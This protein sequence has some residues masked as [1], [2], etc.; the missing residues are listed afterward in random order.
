MS[1]LNSALG[2]INFFDEDVSFTPSTPDTIK[3]WIYNVIQERGF[4]LVNL[5]YIFCSD[6]YLLSIN[7]EYLNHDAYTDII[8]FDHSEQVQELESDIYIS[9]GRV[10]EN[11]S[12]FNKKFDD[13]LHRVMIH[14][15]L[16]LMGQ[17]DKTKEEQLEMRKKEEA[18][19]SLRVE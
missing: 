3:S 19:L 11:A 16:H 5:N 2:E 4:L 9:I 12:Q 15:V 17:G 6:D 10:K 8:T 14:G 7:I 13:E 1:P 18:C